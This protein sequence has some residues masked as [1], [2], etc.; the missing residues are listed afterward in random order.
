MRG[1]LVPQL[2]R[3][4]ARQLALQLALQ[5]PEGTKRATS[6][7]VQLL[8]LQKDL[9]TGSILQD[10]CEFPLR[11]LQAQKWRVHRSRTFG[12]IWSW[13]FSLRFS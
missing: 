3:Q 4:L 7:N 12:G 13:R 5:L 9:P 10:I 1:E 6:V 2:A 8:C 11:A